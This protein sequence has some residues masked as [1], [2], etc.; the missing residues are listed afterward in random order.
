M[1]QNNEVLVT[2]GIPFYNCEKYLAYAIQSV[3]NQSYENWELI[4]LDDGS[5]DSSLNIANS[6]I[7]KRISVISDGTNK[8]LIHRLNQITVMAKGKYY[9]RMDADDIMQVERIAR[10]VSFLN[11]HLEVDLVGSS[12]FSIDSQNQILGRTDIN[13][14][15]KTV[16]SILEKGCFA[17]PSLMGHLTWFKKNKYDIAWERMEDFELWMRTVS[18]SN[19]VN[20]SEPL[21]FYRNV[22][23]PSIKKYIKSNLGIIKLLQYRKKYS[24]SIRASIYYT[25]IYL[26]KISVYLLFFCAGKI[27]FLLK[28]RSH[29]ITENE[30]QTAEEM[31][32][33]SIY[34][35]EYTIVDKMIKL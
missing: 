23:I 26:F 35:S 13:P 32:L 4:L 11:S 6:F 25:S 24:I 14:S 17:H 30:K 20:I 12:Y 19:F 31:L 18:T 28:K 5:T 33:K 2:I 27:D 34:R 10:Q 21:L 29:S 15:P 7:D 3:I 16:E 22:G 9:A 1:N 8:G